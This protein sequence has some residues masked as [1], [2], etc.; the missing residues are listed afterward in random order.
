MPDVIEVVEG[1]V[2]EELAEAL[3]QI[4]QLQAEMT[5]QRNELFNRLA[6]DIESKLTD[7]IGRRGAKQSQMIDAMRLSLGG[8]ATY[9]WIDSDHPFATTDKKS[10]Y[11]VNI[12]RP[13]CEAALAQVIAFQ[14]AGGDKNWQLRAPQ[15]ID[16]DDGDI[17]ATQ[18][19]AQ[20]P[21]DPTQVVSYRMALMEAEMDN[22]LT[23][24]DY[25]REVRKAQRDW[26]YL[27]TGVMK[28]PVNLGKMNKV[29]NKQLTSQGQPIRVP[30]FEMEYLPATYSVNPLL[31]FPDDTVNDVRDC[32]DSIEA[33]PKSKSQLREL[34][35]H[36][37]FDSIEVIA[38]LK[39]KPRSYISNPLSDQGSITA[40]G[41]NFLKDKYLVLEYHGPV[42]GNDLQ[43]AGKEAVYEAEDDVYFAEVWVVN[44]RVIRFELS[45]IEG[46]RKVPYS[47]A[48]WEKDPGSILGFGVPMMIRDEQYAINDCFDMVLDN[49]GISAGPQVIVDTTII[50]PA[51]GGLECTP[52]KVWYTNEY[53]ADT[54][55]AISFFNPPNN[56]EGLSNLFMLLKGIADEA[57]SINLLTSGGDGPSG[58]GDS[59]TSMAIINQ[60]ASSPLF[61]KAEVWDDDITKPIISSVYDWEMQYNP[62]DNIKGSFVVDVRTPT[63]LLRNTQEQQKLERISMEISQGSPLGEIIKMDGLMRARLRL[64]HLPTI[65][66]I[67]S[68]EEVARDK[69]NAPEPPPDPAL[70]EAQAKQEANAIA[71]RKLDLDTQK[72]QME[73]SQ[74]F[75][76]L[77][78]QLAVQ[79]RTND[80]R[81]ME[82]RAS[83]MKAQLDHD[84][85][86]LQLAQRDEQHRA[87]IL[88]SID[89]EKQRAQTARF[90]AGTK[91]GLKVRDQQL[92]EQE[93]NYK[94]ETGK[95]GI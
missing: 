84:A 68:P 66:I 40:G 22:H 54:N 24:T 20:M 46:C 92:N 83:V 51:E 29:Y 56:F 43:V 73:M 27:G 4:T 39:E 80:V 77:K 2:P 57:S 95:P 62:N 67:K 72:L 3:S 1:E 23:K 47:V 74:K 9:D 53:G 76:E 16:I 34:V 89:S 5:A 87:T 70:I 94:R 8:L 64:M 7:R 32:E 71:N 25:A 69:A 61:F 85:Q 28:D 93:L 44:G 60:N 19:Q 36:E 48:V 65:D 50:R 18:Q 33:H 10:S 26:V 78:M 35:N 63:Q 6:G 21:L 37:G 13:K 55:K 14:F 86:L 17:Q 31:W 41:L 81:E 91:V 58:A 90:V 49:A 82:A 38:A 88:A 11:K 30:S 12:T 15:V 79:M 42:S 52:W 59:A 75:E 45:N